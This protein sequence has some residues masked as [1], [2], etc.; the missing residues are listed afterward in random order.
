MAMNR[1][2]TAFLLLGL[3]GA[4]SAAEYIDYAALGRIRQEGF[5]NSKVMETVTTLT[6]RIG[7]RLT[8]SPQMDAANEWT[9]KQL[10]EWGL[11][12]A[13]L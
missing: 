3:A 9:R 4:A 7:P 12:N 13:R 8:N 2:L 5:G 11:S 6:E 10:A 1:S